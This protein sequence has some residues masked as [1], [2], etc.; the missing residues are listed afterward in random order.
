MMRA[1]EIYFLRKF[2]V[3]N[4]VLL[5]IVIILY[6]RCL[7]LFILHN[8]VPSS[9]LPG[10]DNHS[11][12]LCFLTFL[13]STY[14]RHHAVFSYL[15]LACFTQHNNLLIVMILLCTCISKLYAVHLKYI[16][17]YHKIKLKVVLWK[18][19][20]N[21]YTVIPSK[22]SE[23]KERKRGRRGERRGRQG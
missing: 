2:L 16:Q 22:H 18:F 15:C 6:I 13:E 11:S 12:T 5:S 23:K 8:L 1:P 10:P 19:V 7:D 9:H 14:K 3:F 4:I 20:S 21:E 17:F